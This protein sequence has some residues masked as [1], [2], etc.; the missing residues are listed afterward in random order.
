MSYYTET[1][2]T[3]IDVRVTWRDRAAVADSFDDA[4]KGETVAHAMERAQ[5][6]WPGAVIEYLG[7]TQDEPAGVEL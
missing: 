7:I 5:D 3:S 4:I 6:N 1:F 2:P